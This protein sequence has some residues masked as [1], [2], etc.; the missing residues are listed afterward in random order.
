MTL[1][2]GQAYQDQLQP[3]LLQAV[4]D[5]AEGTQV[6]A[7]VKGLRG[8]SPRFHPLAHCLGHNLPG[9]APHHDKPPPASPLSA[10]YFRALVNFTHSIDYSPQ[11]EDAGSEAFREVSEAVVDTVR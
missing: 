8:P 5:I 9:W 7:A 4:L 1:T 10:V 6:S 3:V 11:L 2:P